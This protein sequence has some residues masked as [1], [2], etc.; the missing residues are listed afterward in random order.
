MS[1]QKRA[2]G[3]IQRRNLSSLQGQRELDWT[4]SKS[5]VGAAARFGISPSDWVFVY[6]R[7][8]LH[9]ARIEENVSLSSDESPLLNRDERSSTGPSPTRSISTSHAARLLQAPACARRGNVHELHDTNRTLAGILVKSES[10]EQVRD[11][12]YKC[13][14]VS[15]SMMGPSGWE[16]V[17]LGYLIIK[18]GFVPAR[19]LGWTHASHLRHH[20]PRPRWPFS[21]HQRLSRRRDH[22]RRVPRRRPAAP[23][24][25]S[26]TTPLSCSRHASTLTRAP[27]PFRAG[28]SSVFADGQAGL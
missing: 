26:A 6:F 20:R 27:S 19:T 2:P 12:I 15:G 11:T 13:Q 28:P 9:F 4:V 25:L 8:Q 10:E 17:C 22:A 23:G 16:P 3:E 1:F 14:P 21:H 18:F 7:N 5:N 24:S